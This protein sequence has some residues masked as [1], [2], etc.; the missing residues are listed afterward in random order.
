MIDR[1]AIRIAEN[2]TF[3]AD[4]VSGIDDNMSRS[5]FHPYYELYFLEDGSRSHMLDESLYKTI[6]GDFMIF[7]PYTM[8][9]SFTEG[10]RPFKRIVLYFTPEALDYPLLA[11]KMKHASGL[12][13]PSAPVSRMIHSLL[14]QILM[15]QEEVGE[16][17]EE[18]MRSSLNHLL[19]VILDTLNPEPKPESASRISGIIGYIDNHIGEE[20]RLKDL[21][22]RF[23][24]SEYYLSH[25]FKKH[26]SCTVIE[27]VNHTRIVKAQRMILDTSL[28]FTQIAAQTGFSSL[29][30][31]NRTFRKVTGMSPSDFRRSH[32]TV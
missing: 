20:I 11:E 3:A 7:A 24:I 22:D 8:H 1:A 16:L 19:L 21:A 30:H 15:Q 23:Y 26:T 4:R 25:E 12:Y 17:H 6:P 28:N 10:H 32:R 13:H 14:N 5:H 9:H 18:Y 2:H 31:F 29:T 27:Y